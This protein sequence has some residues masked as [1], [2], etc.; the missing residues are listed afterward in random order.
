MSGGTN[1]ADRSSLDMGQE[2][3]LLGLIEAVNLINEEDG[4]LIT[5][6]GVCAGLFNLGANLGDV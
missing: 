1:E 5:Q 2:D 4:G 6:S 3:V